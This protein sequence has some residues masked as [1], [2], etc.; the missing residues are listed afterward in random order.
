[1]VANVSKN[2]KSFPDSATLFSALEAGTID[3]AMTDTAIVLG[4]AGDSKGALEVVGQYK[5]GESYGAIFPK[6][7]D[8]NPKWDAIIKELIADKT[9]DGLQT[10]YLASLWKGDP[11][12]VPY[13]TA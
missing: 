9:L 3:A 8:N 13:F 2:A 6:A 12:K 4:K 10:T 7:A 5:T 11:A 1:M